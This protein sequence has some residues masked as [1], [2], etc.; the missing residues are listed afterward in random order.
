MADIKKIVE[1]VV[2]YSEGRDLNKIEKIIEPY[3][4]KEG[5]KLLNYEADKDYNR[6]VVTVMG[7]PEAVKNAVVQS[8][9]IAAELIDMT[10]HEGQHS[11]MGATDVVP[12]IPIKNMSMT[13]AVELAKETAKA[14]NEAHDIPVFLYEKAA[15]KPERENLATV[16]KGQFEGMPEKLKDPEW[17]PDFGKCEI[18]PTAGVT[19][20]GARMPLVAYNIDLDTPNV[21][22]AN[23]IAKVIRHSSGGFR[24]IK[25]GGVEIKERGIT[26]V[27]MNITDYTKTSVYRVFETVKMEAKRYGV[28]VLGSEVVG[29]VPMEAL[30]DSAQYY[31]GLYGFSMDKVIET[32]LME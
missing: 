12:F 20:V 16:R 31:L 22:I 10:T 9:G 1:C 18:H 14:I 13:E 25:A 32:S 8:V 29:L 26:Q 27:T 19:A 23:K 28:N 24:Y 30:I 11:R 2:N 7:E 3:R 5:V 21:E 6:V 15:S 4:A 17:K